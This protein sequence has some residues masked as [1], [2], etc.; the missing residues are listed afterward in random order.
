MR[1]GIEYNTNDF[2]GE[3]VVEPGQGLSTYTSAKGKGDWWVLKGGSALPDGIQA[4]PDP[5]DPEHVI[6]SPVDKMSLDDYLERILQTSEEWNW[7]MRIK[8]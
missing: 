8:R 2:T 3:Q 4:I 5:E 1:P 6:L 7:H